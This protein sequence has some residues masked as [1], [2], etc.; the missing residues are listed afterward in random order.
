[1]TVP[2][3]APLVQ[4][5]AARGMEVIATARPDADEWI[6][7]L[8]AAETVDYSNVDIVEQ[9]RKAHPDGIDAL[10]DTTRAQDAFTERATLVRDGGAANS[11]TLVAPPELLASERI[12]VTNYVMRDKPGL[13]ARAAA[14]VAAGRITVPIHRIVTLEEL[15]DALPQ[16]LGGGARGKTTVRI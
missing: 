8:G 11:V 9:V 2:V 15:P 14:E 3:E 16:V 5:A 13:L 12:R 7:S 4:L 10:I 6:R 1:V